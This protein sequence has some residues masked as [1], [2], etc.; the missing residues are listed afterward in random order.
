[1]VDS[2]KDEVTLLIKNRLIVFRFS[3]VPFILNF[4]NKNINL[5]AKRFDYR[6]SNYEKFYFWGVSKTINLLTNKTV[7]KK[8]IYFFRKKNTYSY[9]YLSEKEFL[10]LKIESKKSINWLLRK[11]HLDIITNEASFYKIKNIVKYF[12]KENTKQKLIEKIVEV[13]LKS[14][15]SEPIHLQT[16]FWLKGNNFY[17]Y[18]ILYGFKKD[19]VPYKECNSYIQK[20]SKFNL[21]SKDYFSSLQDMTDVESSNLFKNSPAEITGGAVTS[22]KHRMCAMI[23]RLSRSE[24]YIPI[25]ARVIE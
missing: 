22:G 17:I 19:V 15:L 13:N 7:L 25:Y 5:D 16:D 2:K 20:K 24:S 11:P 23:G 12:K 14:K 18:P 10:N 3:K 21:Y 1:M 9:K 4:K 8:V 6:V